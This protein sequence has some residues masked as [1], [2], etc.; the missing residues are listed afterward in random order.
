MGKAVGRELGGDFGEA[1]LGW[2]G[3][4]FGAHVGGGLGEEIGG[5]L[6]K[7]YFKDGW[8]SPA[9]ALG[10]CYELMGIG[11]GVD[12]KVAKKAYR[13]KSMELHPDKPGGSEEA[14]T[15][16]NI[17]KELVL[18]DCEATARRG[19]SGGG[20]RNVDPEL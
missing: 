1:L 13:R 2:L 12:A 4:H 11:S 9:S 14:M 18:I 16:L 7:H 8:E 10:E 20:R 5:E 19:G 17:C 3:V 6:A 15:K